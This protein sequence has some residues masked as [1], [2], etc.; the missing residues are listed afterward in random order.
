MSDEID[1]AESRI[2]QALEFIQRY[3]GTDGGHHKQWVL[4]QVV[5]LLLGGDGEAY[6]AWRAAHDDGED[7][8]QTYEW[9]EGIPP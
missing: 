1:A 3:G 7:G 8:P 5:R 2:A 4:D 6:R 9:E